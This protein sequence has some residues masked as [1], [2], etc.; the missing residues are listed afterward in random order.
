MVN[1]ARVTAT[2]DGDF[3][4]FLIGMRVNEPLRVHKW[5][6][7]ATAM[8]R[9]IKELYRQPELGF[10]HAEMWFS[11]T[12]IMVQYWRSIDQLLAYAKNR[13]S[14]HLPAW[15]AF[16]K[17]IGTDGSVGIWHETYAVSPG[18]YENIYVNM[19]PFGLGKI[20]SLQPATGGRQSAATRLRGQ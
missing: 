11:R 18:C 7:V 20:G 19:P 1:K 15:Q 6:P 16:N 5:L 2:F 12:T 13:E 3:V 14:E 10:L 17:A 9:M 8:P 4:V